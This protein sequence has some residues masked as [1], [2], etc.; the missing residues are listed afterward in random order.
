[1]ESLMNKKR[2]KFIGLGK[3]EKI[4][5]ELYKDFEFKKTS[6]NQINES[7]EIRPK[8]NEINTLYKNILLSL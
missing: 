5:E 3:G 4:E 8:I 1:M 2:I 6:N 7:L